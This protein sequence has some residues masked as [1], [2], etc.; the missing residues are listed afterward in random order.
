LRLIS[1]SDEPVESSWIPL[2]NISHTRLA[3]DNF[4]PAYFL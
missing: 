1:V 3:S 4:F 2:Q